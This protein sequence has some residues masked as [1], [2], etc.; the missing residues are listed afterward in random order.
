MYDAIQLVTEIEEAV[1]H[2]SSAIRRVEVTDGF[3]EVLD[4]A[5][6]DEVECAA[7][8]LSTAVT[9]YLT[10]AISF[11]EGTHLNIFLLILM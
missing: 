10:R 5:Q 8:V 1:T 3:R 9:D 2:L 6:L 11:L 4:N 7:A